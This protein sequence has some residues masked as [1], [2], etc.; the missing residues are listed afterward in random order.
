M[1]TIPKT[2]S[3][4]LFFQ[5][6]YFIIISNTN[7]V[8]ADVVVFVLYVLLIILLLKIYHK[9]NSKNNSCFISLK[10]VLRMFSLALIIFICYSFA[11]FGLSSLFLPGYSQDNHYEKMMILNATIF[12]PFA[13]EIIFRGILS[14]HI[15]KKRSFLFTNLIQALIFSILHFNMYTFAFHF[16]FGLMLGIICRYRNIYC[17]AL[18]HMFNN[19]LALVLLF[20]DIKIVELPKVA[21]IFISILFSLI[22]IRMMIKLKDNKKIIFEL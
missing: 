8:I 15:N 11:E 9:T 10:E 22:I 6:L 7:S 21:Y 17:C 16:L 18:I 5:I 2:F 13:E 20:F 12:G 14:N 1:K 19:I 4:Y 3:I